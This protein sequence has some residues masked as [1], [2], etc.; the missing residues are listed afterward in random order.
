MTQVPDLFRVEVRL[1][2]QAEQW[3]LFGTRMASFG[4]CYAPNY[5]TQI[6]ANIGMLSTHELS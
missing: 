5:R 4:A 3:T 1:L 2:R 6:A